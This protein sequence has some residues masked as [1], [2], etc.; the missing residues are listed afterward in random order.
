M[1]EAFGFGEEWVL[2]IKRLTSISFFSILINGS[3]TRDF[4]PSRGLQ[5][6]DALSPYLY[7][8]LT[9]GLWRFIQQA[10]SKGTIK[11]IKRHPLTDSVTHLQF[12]DDNF[13]MGK[14]SVREEKA[15]KNVLKVFKEASWDHINLTK[16]Q[17]FLF[18][19]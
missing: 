14:Y 17:I 1:M 12:V 8:I 15:L 5:Q 9:E 16:S 3:P 2:W 19:T 4:N 13:L 11:R 6:G 10:L 18:Y 7:N